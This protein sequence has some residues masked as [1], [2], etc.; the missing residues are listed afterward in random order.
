MKAELSIA[1]RENAVLRVR[2]TG[3]FVRA[4][5]EKPARMHPV[6]QESEIKNLSQ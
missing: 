4:Y 1:K 6:Q 5:D 3:T 2:L